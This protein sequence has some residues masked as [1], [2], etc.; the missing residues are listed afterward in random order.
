MTMHTM[1]VHTEKPASQ[2]REQKQMEMEERRRKVLA[3]YLSCVTQ[4]QIAKQIGV[5][6]ATVSRDLKACRAELRIER[7]ELIE[8][9]AATLDAIERECA[10]RY[11]GDKSGEW[12]DRRIKCMDRRSKLLG[13]DAPTKQQLSGDDGGPVQVV[14]REVV[15]HMAEEEA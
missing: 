7:D 1:T 4:P 12:L 9:E 8:R 15:A 5:D 11:Q 6:Q 2:T 14:I 10:V 3:L 13:L